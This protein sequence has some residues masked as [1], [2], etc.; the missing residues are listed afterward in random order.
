LRWNG[1]MSWCE[2]KLHRLIFGR[3]SSGWHALLNRLR[4]QLYKLH[5]W[6]PIGSRWA[7]IGPNCVVLLGIKRSKPSIVFL[8][9]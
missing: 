8:A 6:F 7:N 3:C 5:R 9:R 4:K 2:K 1:I